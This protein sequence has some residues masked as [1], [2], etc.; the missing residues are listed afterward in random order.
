MCGPAADRFATVISP[1]LLSEL[2]L[3]DYH[4]RAGSDC[5]VF[6]FVI[7]LAEGPVLVDTGVGSGRP[8][9]D[10]AYSPINHPIDDALAEVGVRLEDVRMVI[11]THLHFD[12]CG[13]NHRLPGIPLVV[14]R[15]EYEQIGEPNYTIPEWI[16]FPGAEWELVDGE[17]E[18][19][20]GVKVFPT[21]GHTPGHQSVIVS[22]AERTEIVV[23][24]TAYDTAE[25]DNEASIE[26]VTAAEARLISSSARRIKGI[27]PDRAFF[28]HDAEVWE[29]PRP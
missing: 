2:V 22:S 13:N 16:D 3:P 7:Q 26:P 5:L 10:E 20:P 8:D 11:N 24:Q 9:I 18:V 4:P 14:Q 15:T 1:I 27:N 19:L 23:G 6:G 17:I 28:S 21:P 12:H 25:L 29:P